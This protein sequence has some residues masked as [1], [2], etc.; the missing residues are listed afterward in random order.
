MTHAKSRGIAQTRITTP[1]GPMTALA[2]ADGLAGLWFDDQAHHPGPLTAPQNPDHPTLQA[3]QQW[4]DGYWKG[5]AGM[6]QLRSGNSVQAPCPTLDLSAGTPFQRAVWAALLNIPPGGTSTYAAIAAA[7]GSP[8]AVRA[9]GAAIGRNPVSLVVPCHRVLGSGGALT[10]YAGGL[11]RK[12]AL[13][14]HESAN[15][16]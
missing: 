9:A 6:N 16:A 3:T 12:R 7:A 10:G 8:A 11:E 14:A 1:L 2:T 5:R 15:P 13:L 4:L